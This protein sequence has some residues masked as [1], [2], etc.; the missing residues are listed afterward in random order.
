MRIREKQVRVSERWHRKIKMEAAKLGKSIIQYTEDL[1]PEEELKTCR[2]K[3]GSSIVET[4]LIIVVV[5]ALGIF[6]I[7]TYQAFTDVDDFIQA[8]DWLSNESKNISSDFQTDYPSLMDNAIVFLIVGL[9]AVSWILASRINASPAFF[10]IVILSLFAFLWIAA[11]LSNS[12]EEVVDGAE[13]STFSAQ[14]PKT[15][16]IVDHLVEYILTVFVGVAVVL[17]AKFKS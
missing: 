13:I 3:R 7:Y 9:T 5:I 11:E 6:G 1:T 8:D 10:I 14:Y 2:N 4:Y 17:Y 16:F 12:Y 15:N